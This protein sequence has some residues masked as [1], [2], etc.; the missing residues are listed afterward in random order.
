MNL[1]L[2]INPAD[3]SDRRNYP[4]RRHRANGQIPLISGAGSQEY[5]WEQRQK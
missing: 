3:A 2:F 4:F 5:H 1:F